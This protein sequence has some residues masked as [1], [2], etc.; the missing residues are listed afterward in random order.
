MERIGQL[1][2]GLSQVSFNQSTKRFE[3][4]LTDML[5]CRLV[6]LLGASTTLSTYLSGEIANNSWLTFFLVFPL[7]FLAVLILGWL[8]ELM[9]AVVKDGLSHG[10]RKS[11]RTEKRVRVRRDETGVE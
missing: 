10:R 2:S 5:T 3:E 11:A 7:M 9:A 6:V 8:V 4:N 1:F